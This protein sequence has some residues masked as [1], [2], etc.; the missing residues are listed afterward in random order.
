MIRHAIILILG[1]A[2]TA[3]ADQVEAPQQKQPNIIVI[4]ADDLAYSDIEPYGG[5]IDTPNLAR[6]ARTGMTF[7]YY[8]TP[9]MCSP[10]RAMLLTGV[11]QHRTGYGTMAEFL[12]DNQKGQPGYEGYLNDKVT[13][14][15]QKLREQG[16]RTYMS[17]KWHLGAR[18]EPSKRGFD[19]SFTLIEGAG[20]HFDTSG[21][22]EMAPTVTYL[23]DGRPTELPDDFYSTD[24]YTDEL[25][26]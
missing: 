1:I 2:L 14:I 7:T 25:I 6:L 8:H 22:G 11:A 19:R 23:R 13:T 24:A 15:A 16:Y 4:L 5:E 12:A 21:Y 26:E 9:H 17:G 18:S 20:S 10:S 3:C